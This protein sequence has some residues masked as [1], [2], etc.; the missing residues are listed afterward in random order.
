MFH[1]ILDFGARVDGSEDVS[2]AIAAALNSCRKHNGGVLYFPAGLY[3]TG[4]VELCENLE[5]RLDPG[6]IVSFSTDFSAYPPR[7]TR[8]EGV[9]CHGY[10]PCIYGR[11]L[12]NV[13]IVGPGTLDGNGQAWWDEKRRRGAERLLGPQTEQDRRLAE[14]NPGYETAGSGGGGRE[15]QFLRP[16]LIQLI[17]CRRV[18][19]RDFTARNSPFWNTHLVYCEDVVVDGIRIRNPSDAPNGD[20]LSLDSCRHV[21]VINCHIDAGDDCLTLKSGMD[22]DGRRVGRPT[23][24]VMI[25]NCTF[26]RGHGGIVCGSE[27]ASGIRNIAVSNCVFTNADRGIRVKARRGRGG[28]VE[29]FRASNLLMDGALCPI[30]FNSY[31]F[32]GARG[33]AHAAD[34]KPKAVDETTPHF[35]RIRFSG[36]TA[37]NSRAALGYICGLPE[38]P[39]MDLSLNDVVLE[40]TQEPD[41]KPAK[42]AMAYD[43]ERT[44]GGGLFLRH[45][46]NLSL[47][48]CILRCLDKRPIATDDVKHVSC[49]NVRDNEGREQTIVTNLNEFLRA[50][51]T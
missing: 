39:V 14:L 51:R 44:L 20:G 5:I 45:V 16:P 47:R 3:P 26:L 35:H 22:A 27:L 11:G 1:S 10:S 40:C 48:D 46:R 24:N 2:A 32:C 9:E 49:E 6:A 41:A 38:E 21:R 12:S 18:T 4:P 30:V 8:W 33:D 13:H 23:E 19:L 15:S 7:F 43:A 29:D 50:T 42:A 31:Y 36:I 17:D 28:Y 37:R 34:L 25:S